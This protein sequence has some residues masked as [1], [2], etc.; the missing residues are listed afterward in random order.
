MDTPYKNTF[1]V[2]IPATGR[3]C[4]P[5]EQACLPKAGNEC[6]PIWLYAVVSLVVKPRV[7]VPISR[8]RFPY[9]CPIFYALVTELGIRTGLRNQ[10][11]RVRV[12][13]RAPKLAL[14]DGVQ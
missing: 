2:G 7:V 14:I 4:Y 3:R 6:V 12:S 1:T 5:K 8:V 9:F 10:V 13:P 11:L